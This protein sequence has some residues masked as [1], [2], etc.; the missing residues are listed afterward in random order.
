MPRLIKDL[1]GAEPVNGLGAPSGPTTTLHTGAELCITVPKLRRP[2]E[3]NEIY[4]SEIRVEGQL[5]R[6]PRRALEKALAA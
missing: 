4:W 1:P 6:V 3:T 2:S 5:Y